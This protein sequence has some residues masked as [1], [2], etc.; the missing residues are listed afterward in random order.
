MT[1]RKRMTK[2]LLLPYK[3]QLEAKSGEAWP[4]QRVAEESGVSDETLRAA[5]RDLTAVS[6]ST[7]FDLEAFFRSRGVPFAARDVLPEPTPI[8]ETV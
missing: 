6:L 4:W 2:D 3:G 7:L 5:R 1:T 8:L